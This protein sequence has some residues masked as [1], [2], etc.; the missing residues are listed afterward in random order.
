MALVAALGRQHAVPRDQLAVDHRGGAHLVSIG[1]LFILPGG[2]QGR[3]LQRAEGCQ[4]GALGA[5]HHGVPEII[6][7]RRGGNRSKVCADPAP[8]RHNRAGNQP[9]GKRR[10]AELLHAHRAGA[11]PHDGD[12]P[13]IAAE[14]RNVVM[15][16]LQRTELVIQTVVAGVAGFG[17][18]FGQAGKA[19][20]PEAVV[21]GNR[22]DPFG[23]PDRAVEVLFI[24]AA[25][26]KAAA[27]DVKQHRKFG[28]GGGFGR[29]PDIQE[30]AVF[31][32]FVLFTAP[33]LIVIE[34]F[35]GHLFLIIKGAG[36]VAG[37]AVSRRLV[38]A[39]PV[40]D[41]GGVF[42]PAGRGIADAF[43]GDNARP[44]AAAAHNR[45]AGGVAGCIHGYSFFLPALGIQGLAAATASL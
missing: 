36:L 41:R 44:L 13:G 37:G 40:G 45:A 27:V 42:P 43:E 24:P 5:V 4:V 32:V 19:K 3:R 28:F 25:A 23:R 20:R 18:K 38:G 9:F 22:D 17:R 11:L 15:H 10:Q 14:R 31:A 26:G 6:V 7:G 33:E 35:F 2:K 34:R 8:A 1:R 21:D 16:P 29:S 12:A 39:L 30:Q